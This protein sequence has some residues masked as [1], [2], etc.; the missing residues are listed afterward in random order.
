MKYHIYVIYYLDYPGYEKT[1]P[2]TFQSKVR[3]YTLRKQKIFHVLECL[4][5]L[6]S[7][8][9]KTFNLTY[10]YM[11]TY[12]ICRYMYILYVYLQSEGMYKVTM[13]C[14]LETRQ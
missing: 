13:R 1:S 6:V 9:F 5:F 12:K 8:V 10:I 14:Y 3:I 11:Y 7:R 4:I 2:Y